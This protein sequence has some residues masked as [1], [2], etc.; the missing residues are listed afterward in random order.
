MRDDCRTLAS[1]F[2]KEGQ[3][4]IEA[5]KAAGCFDEQGDYPSTATMV[6]NA[7]S[8]AGRVIAA[9]VT[10][11][12]VQVPTEEFERRYALCRSNECGQYDSAQDRCIKCGCVANLKTRL[13]TEHCPLD[14]PKW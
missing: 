12:A 7:L 6:G 3:A 9:A 4:A 10:G 5:M 1:R 11:E 14:P 8:A 2:P 13:A